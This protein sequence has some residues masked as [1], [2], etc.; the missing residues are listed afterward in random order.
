[1]GVWTPLRYRNLGA[2]P[3]ADLK[4]ENFLLKNRTG[5]IEKDNLR[6]V[7]FGLSTIHHDTQIC[8]QIVGSGAIR[9]GKVTGTALSHTA[10][11]LTREDA[12]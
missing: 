9:P 4:P 12:S 6:A 8:K 7:D 2:M 3:I 11:G 5:S 10:D 1:M